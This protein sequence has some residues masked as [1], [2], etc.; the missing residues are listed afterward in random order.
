MKSVNQAIRFFAILF[1]VAVGLAV[2]GVVTGDWIFFSLMLLAA[3]GALWLLLR[4]WDM[5]ER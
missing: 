2:D 1:V 4:G 3:G 5:R